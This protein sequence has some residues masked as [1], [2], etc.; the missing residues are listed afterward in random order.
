MS[1]STLSFKLYSNT[2]IWKLYDPHALI[3][4]LKSIEVWELDQCPA[5][6]QD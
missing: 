1:G 6:S 3:G 2:W 5:A 4:K